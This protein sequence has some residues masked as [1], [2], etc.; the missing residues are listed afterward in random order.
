MHYSFSSPKIVRQLLP[1]F[2]VLFLTNP[3][4]AKDNTPDSGVT[5]TDISAA[6]NFQREAGEGFVGTA[7]LDYDADDDL[8]VLIANDAGFANGLFRNDGD[9]QFTDVTLA[10]GLTSNSGNSGIVVG[11][12]D[13]DGY[14]DIFMSGAGH[15]T[16][17]A[18]SPT[19]LFHNNGDGTFTDIAP[20][21]DVPG[22]ETALSAAMADINN[23]GYL[24]L[25]I[26]SPGH[27]GVR[28][29]PAAQ[30][31]DR[32]YLNNGDLTF[33]DISESAGVLGGLGSCA[34][35]FSDYDNDGWMDLYVGICNDIHFTPRPFHLY[36]NNGDSTFT[37]V[38]V[39]AG[40]DKPGFWMA[41]A[42]GDIDNDGD[43]D[44]F[45]TSSGPNNPPFGEQSHVLYRNNGDGSYTDIAPPDM[46]DSEFGWGASFADYDND[47]FVDLFFSGSLPPLGVVGPGLGN[48][49]RLFFND[50]QGGFVQNSAALGVDL[51][52]DFVSGLAQADF[53]R[54]GFPDLFIATSKIIVP[55]PPGP[56]T[57]VGSGAPVLLQ[58]NGNGNHW[59]TVQLEG[60]Q[61]NRMG[62][63]ARIDLYTRGRHGARQVREIRAGSSF[64][65]C[66]TPWPTFGL[67]KSKHASVKVTWPSG[68]VDW[69]SITVKEG[70][71]VTLVE[72]EGIN[73]NHHEDDDDDDDHSED[74]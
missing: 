12:I 42:L 40:I 63:G 15:F 14:P 56:P 24:D 39:Q 5:F 21:A 74:E 54:N 71:K 4:F 34:A 6:I 27:L 26:T 20:T 23:D 2:A 16:G 7:W 29:P 53:D 65:S 1:G 66:E 64:A 73:R 19:R 45:A 46:A 68:V 55:N 62:I 44:L 13:N 18:Q 47:G 17:P 48:P 70:K 67:G 33:T 38:A 52:S 57:I 22:G 30:H 61:S 11:D 51:S 31:T 8:D 9:N 36:R 10:A 43:F 32:L 28:F 35:A 59:L 60:T 69:H 50:G 37:D 41:V 25:F 58:N 3:I 49:G 72:G